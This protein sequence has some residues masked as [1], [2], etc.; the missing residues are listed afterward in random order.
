[1]KKLLLILADVF[2]L[3]CEKEIEPQME[4]ETHLNCFFVDEIRK[5][6]NGEVAYVIKFSN[7]S[8]WFFLYDQDIEL[9]KGDILE[10]SPR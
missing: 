6:D 3:G 8:D 2:L 4:G 5:M 10:L 9:K 7:G 1:M